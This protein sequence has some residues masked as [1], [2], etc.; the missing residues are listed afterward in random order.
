MD[1]LLPYSYPAKREAEE[2]EEHHVPVKQQNEYEEGA[3]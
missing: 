1:Q 3:G 2:L